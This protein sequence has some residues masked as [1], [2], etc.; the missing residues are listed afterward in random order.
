MFM[1]TLSGVDSE[2]QLGRLRRICGGLPGTSE[3]L[4]HGEPAFFVRKKIYAMFSSN[5]RAD[6]RIAASI[7]ARPGEQEARIQTDRAVYYRPPY[8]GVTGWVGVELA[9][10]GDEELAEHLVSAW[11]IIGKKK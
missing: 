10:I 5:H 9:R 2:E 4:S 6:G 7:P 3:K 1:D 11:R 8:E